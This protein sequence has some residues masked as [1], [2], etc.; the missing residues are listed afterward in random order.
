MLNN[1]TISSV[2]TERVQT[3]ATT[4]STT[5]CAKRSGHIKPFQA[6]SIEE[7]KKGLHQRVSK[8]LRRKDR[9][10]ISS[11]FVMEVSEPTTVLIGPVKEKSFPQY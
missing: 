2:A 8:T 10:N 7:G 6:L 4:T 1:L 11:S 3:A 9:A 5:I